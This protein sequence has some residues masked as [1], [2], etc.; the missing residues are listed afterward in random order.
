MTVH[1]QIFAKCIWT[2]LE[3]RMDLMHWPSWERKWEDITLWPPQASSVGVKHTNNL[4][5]HAQLQWLIFICTLVLPSVSIVRFS[6]VEEAA[7]SDERATRFKY[8][9]CLAASVVNQWSSQCRTNIAHCS[10]QVR[11]ETW[12]WTPDECTRTWL[13]S[14]HA[15]RPLCADL[16]HLYFQ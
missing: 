1:T 3:L 11:M 5:S 15:K 4:V 16:K 14:T 12:L 9:S 10:W 2:L 8:F 13:A 7:L 6:V